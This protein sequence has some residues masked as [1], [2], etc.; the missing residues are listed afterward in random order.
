M[1]GCRAADASQRK[2]EKA[3]LSRQKTTMPRSRDKATSKGKETCSAR[4]ENAK[5][6]GEGRAKNPFLRQELSAKGQT[7]GKGEGRKERKTRENQR[8]REGRR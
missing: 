7:T 6:S 3:P 4:K 5:A 1:P 8:E 2:K